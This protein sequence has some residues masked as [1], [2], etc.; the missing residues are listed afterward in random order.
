MDMQLY[1]RHCC[2]IFVLLNEDGVFI[3]KVGQNVKGT[4]FCVSADNQ[5]AHGL[6]GIV[7]SFTA[8][9]VYRFCMATRTVS[10]N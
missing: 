6:S 10:S 5:G 3:E 9:Y 7:E 2:V 8:G 4:I 1:L